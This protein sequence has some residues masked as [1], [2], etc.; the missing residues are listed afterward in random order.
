MTMEQA[1]D[2]SLAKGDEKQ[3]I[4]SLINS[5]LSYGKSVRAVPMTEPNYCQVAGTM[6]A[7]VDELL[8]TLEQV[9]SLLNKSA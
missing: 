6:T 2:P 5:A 9:Q 7:A 3:Y 1:T 4:M 8:S